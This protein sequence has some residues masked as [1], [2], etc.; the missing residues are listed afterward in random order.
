[1]S[2]FA[3]TL[4]FEIAILS[5]LIYSA[6]FD[7]KNNTIP[8]FVFSILLAFIIPI[9]V[10]AKQFNIIESIFG[11]LIGISVFLLMALFFEGG[12][13]DVL[14]MGVLGWILGIRGI[15]FLILASSLTYCSFA[16]GAMLVNCVCKRKNDLRK[17]Y[18]FAPFVLVGYVVYLF[19]SYLF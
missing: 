1:M 14:M 18:P 6:H 15:A 2:I 11:T 4:C 17:Q 9:S 19:T 13:G 8:I 16:T 12:G 3:Y 7:Y 5:A 10:I